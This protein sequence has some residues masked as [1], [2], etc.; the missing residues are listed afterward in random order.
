MRVITKTYT[1]LEATTYTIVAGTLGTLLFLPTAAGEIHDSS[2]TVNLVI[3]FMGVF[4]AALAYLSWSYALAKAKKTAHVTVF[5]YLIPLISTLLAYVWLHES[6]SVFTFIGGLIIIAGMIL[7][8]VF[9]RGE[10][11]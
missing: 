11:K 9:D 1:A 4:P 10:E 5:S 7:T 2:L 3:V 8:N 6:L